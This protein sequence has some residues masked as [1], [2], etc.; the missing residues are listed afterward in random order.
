MLTCIALYE[1]MSLHCQ[2]P[3]HIKNTIKAFYKIHILYIGVPAYSILSK[4][5]SAMSCRS[6]V[7]DLILPER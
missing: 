1:N 6:L 7:G 3:I 5:Y 4:V 2:L